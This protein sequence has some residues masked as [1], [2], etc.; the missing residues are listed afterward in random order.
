MVDGDYIAFR[1]Q[2]RLFERLAAYNSPSG[3]LTGA[4]EPMHLP[5]NVVTADFFSLLGVNAAIGRTFLPGEDQPGHDHVALLSDKLWR[6]RFGANPGI[7]GK[8][9]TLDGISRTVVGVMPAGFAFPNER[10]LW[11][12]L[13]IQLD[14]RNSMLLPVLGRLKPGV[15]K[16]QAQ[17]ELETLAP[18]RG[19]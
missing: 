4:G 12:P 10:E 13:T 7:V 15:S 5:Y 3:N 6:N 9:I 14:P 8:S 18:Q 17:A 11:T 19:P 1:N 2:D 16:R